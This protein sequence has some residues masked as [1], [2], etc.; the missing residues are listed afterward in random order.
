[1]EAGV[2]LLAALARHPAPTW[3]DGQ[4]EDDDREHG[5][6]GDVPYLVR[7]R[8]AGLTPEDIRQALDRARDGER[9]A[10]RHADTGDEAAHATAAGALAEWQRVHD[11]TTVTGAGRYDPDHDSVLQDALRREHRRRDVAACAREAAHQARRTLD[12]AHRRL[13]GPAARSVCTAL[14]AIPAPA[15]AAGPRPTRRPTFPS[16]SAARAP[17]CRRRFRTCEPGSHTRE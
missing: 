4:D 7:R 5:L 2:T 10:D 3:D 1:M 11:H 9:A 16:G 17:R 14:A 13:A 6:L 8:A 15:A 12:A